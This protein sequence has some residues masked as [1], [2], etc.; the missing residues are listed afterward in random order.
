MS[1]KLSW[2]LPQGIALDK[3]VIYRATQRIST[4]ALPAPL[5]ELAG[6][7]AAY[8]DV[9]V[10]SG[11]IYYYIVA[12]VKG[13]QISFS[14]NY[15]IGYF[16][17]TGPG[18]QDLMRGSWERGYFGTLSDAEFLS[19]MD[20]KE[21]L[22]FPNPTLTSGGWHKLIYK[23][24]I[25]FFPINNYTN[26]ISWNTLYALGAV[27]GDDTNGDFIAGYN[28]PALRKQDARVVKD[29][30]ELR[31]RIPKVVDHKKSYTAY[32]HYA[33]TE[34]ADLFEMLFSEPDWDYGVGRERLYD[35]PHAQ[36]LF[37][38]TGFYSATY[39][40]VINGYNSCTYTRPTDSWNY[41]PV[42]ELIL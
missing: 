42:L 8:E 17:S 29:G 25:L 13:E 2:A 28:P 40:N 36:M 4:G 15:E 31:V 39:V 21:Q 35:Q 9:A 26:A 22:G 11:N 7:A 12:L 5:V 24:K 16:S 14:S 20:I 38:A 19:Y 1:I 10:T 33:G 27:F 37:T 3:V 6:D 23:G 30:F 41:R 18:P 32:G 34:I